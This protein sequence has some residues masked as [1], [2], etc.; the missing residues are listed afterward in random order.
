VVEERGCYCGFLQVW[1]AAGRE[2][3]LLC[4]TALLWWTGEE[5]RQAGWERGE[6]DGERRGKRKIKTRGEGAMSLLSAE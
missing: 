3:G 1:L 5:E 4:L 6:E 2:T